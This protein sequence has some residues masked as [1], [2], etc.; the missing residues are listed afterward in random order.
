MLVCVLGS[1]EV[2]GA[3][4]ISVGHGANPLRK[5]ASARMLQQ[6]T[7][8]QKNATHLLMRRVSEFFHLITFRVWSLFYLYHSAIAFAD[9]ITL[10]SAY[11]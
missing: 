5:V 9:V 3:S 1:G 8:G 4:T 10:G 7:E 6:A 2:V 11:Q